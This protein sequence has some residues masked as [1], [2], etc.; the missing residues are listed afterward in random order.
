M[1]YDFEVRVKTDE[2]WVL[3]N[4][5]AGKPKEVKSMLKKAGKAKEANITFYD[6][7]KKIKVLAGFEKI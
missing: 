4:T 1:D 6:N 5:I 7:S 2:G 3:A